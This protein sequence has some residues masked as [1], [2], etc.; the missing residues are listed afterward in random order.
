M[1]NTQS[2]LSDFVWKAKKEAALLAL[3]SVLF[4][5]PLYAQN[6]EK[7]APATYRQAQTQQSYRQG[8]IIL[9][10]REP[11]KTSYYVE[12]D[13]NGHI[14]TSVTNRGEG[15]TTTSDQTENLK[16]GLQDAGRRIE[17]K[18]REAKDKGYLRSPITI[19]FK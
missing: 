7:Q 5:A 4:T 17:K 9:L 6:K 10:P 11:P 16:R 18:L 15:R 3:G 14:K 2:Y 12:L 13:R 1:E 8:R 19:K